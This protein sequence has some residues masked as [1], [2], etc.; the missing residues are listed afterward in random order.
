MY[1]VKCEVDLRIHRLEDL[2]NLK[3]INDENGLKTN[4]CEIARKL[5]VDRRTAKKYLEGYEKPSRRH[6]PSG[7]EVYRKTI[8][9][10]LRSDTQVFYY[11]RVLYQFLV[12]NYGLT[13]PL[14]TFY[15]YLKTVPEFDSYFRKTKD[16]SIHPVIRYETGAGEQAQ[17]DWKEDI[18]FVLADTKEVVRINVL[19][20]L[21]GY[22]RL[23]LYKLSLQKTQEVV[24]SLL[25]ECFEELGGVPYQLL[26]DNMKTVMDVPR[27]SHNPGKINER[28]AVFAK[29]FGFEVKPCVARTPETKGKVEAPMKILDELRAYSGTLTMVQ[30]ADKLSEINQRVNSQFNQGSGGIPLIDFGKEKDSLLPLPHETI[31]NPYKIKTTKAKVNA[32]SMITIQG[33]YYSVPPAYVGKEVEYQLH[34]SKVYVYYTTRLIAVHTISDKKLNYAS[35]DYEEILSRSYPGRSEDD[36]KAM[37]KRNLDLIGE[38]YANE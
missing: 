25:T 3:M 18:P 38:R 33:N 29:D 5:G 2:R 15:H 21:M 1:Q 20:L 8:S 26:T 31:R 30:L 11:R 16:G 4:V 34:D 24:L 37:A 17:L 32:S 9:D 28:F 14:Q 19:T 13:A 27:S 35:A 6:K 10:L 22:S 36:I 23:R 7:L 12:D